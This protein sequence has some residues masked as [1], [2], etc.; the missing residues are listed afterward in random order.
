MNTQASALESF[1]RLAVLIFFANFG[2]FLAFW[3]GTKLIVE[4]LLLSMLIICLLILI[5]KKNQISN[6]AYAVTTFTKGYFFYL[7]PPVALFAYQFLHIF[8]YPDWSWDSLW[9]H[10]PAAAT[11]SRELNIETVHEDSFA[12]SY[13]GGM[14]ILQAILWH[15][16]PIA[17]S[18]LINLIIL[19]ILTVAAT[20][21]VTYL[22]LG[23][24]SQF[25][26][27]LCSMA[28]PT[29]FSQ[30]L[31]A[32]TDTQFGFL[33]FISITLTSIYLNDNSKS[34]LFYG[35]LAFAGLAC[36]LKYQGIALLLIVLLVGNFVNTRNLWKGR[37]NLRNF[38]KFFLLSTL[39]GFCS[40]GWLI[41]NAFVFQNPIYP[42]DFSLGPFVLA[43][44]KIG[45]PNEAFLNRESSL[46]S[47]SNNPLSFLE[48]F[49]HLTPNFVYDARNGGFGL[50]WP[51]FFSLA[52]VAAI[53]TKGIIRNLFFL[54]LILTMMSPANWWPRY[55]IHLALASIALAIFV[56]KFFRKSF[57]WFTP[58]LVVVSL[59]QLIL[60]LPFLGPYPTF[61][62]QP[63]SFQEI[64]HPWT[65]LD[66]VI[67][68]LLVSRKPENVVYPEL[69]VLRSEIPLKVAFWWNK[70]LILPLLGKNFRNEIQKIPGSKF[71][72]G[73]FL[74]VNR[75][76]YFVTRE[77]QEPN[78]LPRNCRLI[79]N[80][81][82][83]IYASKVYVCDWN[84]DSE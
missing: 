1:S 59:L 47:H 35:S 10:S 34:I 78:F 27:L 23:V 83:G 14:A 57:H 28:L 63:T 18:Q 48:G 6:L 9:Y 20:L 17:P 74:Q 60:F 25:A 69:E 44:G 42:F 32:Y 73:P 55:Q 12:N 11:W 7:L 52:I 8:T 50:L 24:K 30:S 45:S 71:D 13:P 81:R 79:E 82:T 84:S 4:V 33:V 40:L 58:S 43:E 16:E 72:V 70:P 80:E 19:S 5:G 56:C 54:S 15:Y 51:I 2:I 36:F 61:R 38:S 37:I 3:L 26:F 75:P 67:Q 39:F 76:D 53:K 64:M 68:T 41:R 22:G 29:V 66:S 31:T 21:L 77:A 65:S 46:S 49:L 62:A